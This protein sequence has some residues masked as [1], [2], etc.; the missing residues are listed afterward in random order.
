MFSLGPKFD[1]FIE[2]TVAIRAPLQRLLGAERLD[3]LFNDIAEDQYEKKLLFST[4]MNL[5]LH[6]TQ[7][8]S[9]SLRQASPAPRF[10]QGLGTAG[11]TGVCRHDGGGDPSQ[12]VGSTDRR[13]SLSEIASRSEEKGGEDIRPCGQACFDRSSPQ[14]PK[15]KKIRNEKSKNSP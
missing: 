4:V 2:Q 1:V 9:P 5:M 13:V 7:K 8:N 12:G 6:V 10:A 11:R 15:S 3:R 14:R